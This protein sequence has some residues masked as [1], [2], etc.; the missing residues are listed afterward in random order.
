MRL[1]RIHEFLGV[2]GEGVVDT[3]LLGK[4]KSST[5]QLETVQVLRFLGYAGAVDSRL[6]Q[7]MIESEV[8]AG[9][10][11]HELSLACHKPTSLNAVVLLV[12]TALGGFS[13]ALAGTCRRLVKGLLSWRRPV[14]EFE[15]GNSLWS[16]VTAARGSGR[17]PLK[18][19]CCSK[20]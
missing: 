12:G 1:T 11:N 13:A 2:G 18:V 20:V 19:M 16:D 15:A 8:F 17:G 6:K 5:V 10:S 14:A 4:P 9:N 7:A 3:R